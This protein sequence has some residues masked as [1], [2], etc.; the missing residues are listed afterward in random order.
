M[1]KITKSQFQTSKVSTEELES[2]KFSRHA[3]LDKPAP[4]LDPGPAPDSD[5]G[6]SRNHMMLI[7]FWIL[8]GVYPARHTGRE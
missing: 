2:L 7:I 1:T 3:G 5:P 6:A 8:A 4:D